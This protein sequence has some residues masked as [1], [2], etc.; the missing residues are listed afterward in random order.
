MFWCVQIWRCEWRSQES[1]SNRITFS[2]LRFKYKGSSCQ[3]NAHIIAKYKWRASSYEIKAHVLQGQSKRF[4]VYSRSISCQLYDSRWRISL[5]CIIIQDFSFCCWKTKENKRTHQSPQNF[6]FFKYGSHYFKLWF[7]YWN[8][9]GFYPWC[10]AISHHSQR[11]LS[12]QY[13]HGKK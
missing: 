11:F 1:V 6:C 9:T 4:I 12:F 2:I 3:E 5:P 8:V 13:E 7:W 10:V